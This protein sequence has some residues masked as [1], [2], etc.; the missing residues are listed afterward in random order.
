MKVRRDQNF[1]DI[2]LDPQDAIEIEP[3]RKR[4]G[5]YLRINGPVQVGDETYDAI[6]IVVTNWTSSKTGRTHTPFTQLLKYAGTTWRDY[7][8]MEP[9]EK[10]DTIR[11]AFKA[12]EGEQ[13]LVLRTFKTGG[14]D[15]KLKLKAYTIVTEEF[16]PVPHR[17]I[18]ERVKDV[19]GREPD[20]WYRFKRRTL[21][22][23]KIVDMGHYWYGIAITNANTGKHSIKVHIIAGCGRALLP[24]PDTLLPVLHRKRVYHAGESLDRVSIIVRAYYSGILELA[25]AKKLER[26]LAM[27]GRVVVPREREIV[28]ELLLT[29][30]KK[31]RY[32]VEREIEENRKRGVESPWHIVLALEK[33]LGR[34]HDDRMIELATRLGRKIGQL[35]AVQNA[36]TRKNQVES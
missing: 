34:A 30:P 11:R 19:L 32:R 24:L 31:Y 9:E 5:F 6:E 27:I 21:M 28:S 29:L 4:K 10:A 20:I 12:R 25:H 1:Y 17:E 14:E 7:K 16:T 36:W 8:E 33:V 13:R 18:V 26:T 35:L 2:I 15:G 22:A 3:F 23:W